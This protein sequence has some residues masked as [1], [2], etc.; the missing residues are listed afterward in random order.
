MKMNKSP[1]CGA[2]TVIRARLIDS[3]SE[4][5]LIGFENWFCYPKP[6]NHLAHLFFAQT[7]FVIWNNLSDVCLKCESN[8]CW[9]GIEFQT[10]ACEIPLAQQVNKL[11]ICSVGNSQYKMKQTTTKTFR[12][13]MKWKKNVSIGMA[14][15]RMSN[16]Q[17]DDECIS[18]S[19]LYRRHK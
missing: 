8:F 9:F 11:H 18:R 4:S 10:L 2:I 6:L 19:V 17:T 1:K 16:R 13:K 14:S 5:S 12:K 15:A 3:S 7:L